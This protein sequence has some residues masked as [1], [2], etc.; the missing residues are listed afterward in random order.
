ML[1]VTGPAEPDAPGALQRLSPEVR[2]RVMQGTS[3]WMQM[4][5]PD[6]FNRILDDFLRGVT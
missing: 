2:H 4:D 5:K 6:E 1:S 3:H